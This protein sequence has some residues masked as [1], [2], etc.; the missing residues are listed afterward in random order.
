MDGYCEIKQQ[1]R[2]LRLQ[3][4]IVKILIIGTS[5]TM[6][7]YSRTERRGNRHVVVETEKE[8]AWVCVHCEKMRL[9]S[10]E[11]GTLGIASVW[12]SFYN[13]VYTRNLLKLWIG[14]EKRKRKKDHKVNEIEQQ[15]HRGTLGDINVATTFHIHFPHGEKHTNSISILFFKVL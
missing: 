12:T 6:G 2:L 13:F 9:A 10:I 15:N 4:F 14:G 1:R 7:F 3:T 11:K 8:R 5:A